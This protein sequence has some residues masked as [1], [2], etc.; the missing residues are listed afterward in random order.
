MDAATI[1][2]LLL[3]P[4]I[5]SAAAED[6]Q[7]A[8]LSGLIFIRFVKSSSSASVTPQL[9]NFPSEIE[10]RISSNI[11]EYSK[12]FSLITLIDTLAFVFYIELPKHIIPNAF[13][14]NSISSSGKSFS[15]GA[16]STHERRLAVL[17]IAALHGENICIQNR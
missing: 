14:I 13:V 15:P 8:L 12:A 10:R 11:V 7:L 2:A 4:R 5:W 17:R 6:V 1:L 3:S 16:N 9:I